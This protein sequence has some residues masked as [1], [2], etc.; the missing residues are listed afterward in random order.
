MRW[1][2]REWE[3]GRVSWRGQMSV[4]ER[5]MVCGSDRGRECE[6]ERGRERE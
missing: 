6:W 3:G 2:R 1:I 4:R 5:W